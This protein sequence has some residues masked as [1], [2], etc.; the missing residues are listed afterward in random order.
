MQPKLTIAQLKQQAAARLATFVEPE[1]ASEEQ[2]EASSEEA[3]AYLA[4]EA[5]LTYDQPLFLAFWKW[6][7]LHP[8][9]PML[10]FDKLLVVFSGRPVLATFARAD[11]IRFLP[12]LT[13]NSLT[14]LFRIAHLLGTMELTVPASLH[15]ELYNF[16]TKEQT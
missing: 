10:E 4:T 6:L 11:T 1:E 5:D 8:T 12:L 3:F 14:E 2:A 7:L 15:D 13:P 9:Y 16:L